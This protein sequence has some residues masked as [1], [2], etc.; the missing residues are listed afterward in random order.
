M[1]TFLKFTLTVC[2]VSLGFTIF[3]QTPL[4]NGSTAA[5][6]HGYTGKSVTFQASGCPTTSI[7]VWKF[8]TKSVPTQDLWAGAFQTGSG[9]GD[10]PVTAYTVPLGG[11]LIRINPK[12]IPH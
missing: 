7:Y 2:L 4:I 1:N 9:S 8:S 3:A 6:I 5:E 11:H 10:N 12:T